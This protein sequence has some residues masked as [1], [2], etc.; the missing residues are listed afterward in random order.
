MGVLAIVLALV[1]NSQRTARH[2]GGRGASRR[3]A[4]LGTPASR[5]P[6]SPVTNRQWE[7]TGRRTLSAMTDPTTVITRPTGSP[8]LV[9]TWH[10]A[11]ADFVALA[12][13]LPREQWD[14][15]TDLDGLDGQGQRRAHRPPRG[16]P[17]RG[18]RGDRRG[19]RGTAPEGL[20][21]LLHR[22][23]RPRPARPRHGRAR[24]RDRAVGRPPLR[25][26]A[27]RLRR[28]TASPRLR[29]PRA[30]RAGTSRRCWATGPSTCGCTSR[31]YAA[32][33][34]AP[35]ATTP[36][37]PHTRSGPWAGRCRWWSASASH[38]RLGRPSGWRSRMPGSAG[39]CRSATT[40]ERRLW[41]TPTSADDEREPEPGGLRRARGWPARA[42]ATHPLI[43]GDHET[44]QRLSASM[45]V[46]P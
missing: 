5:R 37:L 11:C 45:A 27:G 19:R 16:R 14:L 28:P 42:E 23:G 38:R 32:R 25:R 41:P 46:T 8:Q 2:H 29:G 44:A 40:V 7:R 22:A 21:E 39:P 30:A 17:R 15:P 18:P 6:V 13:S 1:M 43:E 36:L 12:R 10:G 33:S 31:T 26:A 35:V 24:R 34:T 4:S 9:E 20:R 3:P